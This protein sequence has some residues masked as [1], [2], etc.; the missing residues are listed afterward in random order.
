MKT[1][2][3]WGILGAGIIIAG[4]GYYALKQQKAGDSEVA[5]T[6]NSKTSEESQ[7][8]GKFTGSFQSLL[9]RSGSWKCTIDVSTQ[10]AVSS[11]VTY[12]SNGKVRGDF[13]SGV[14][15][16]GNIESHIIADGT[17]AYTWTSAYPQGFKVKLAATTG[18]SNNGKTPQT[19]GNGFD[20]NQNYSYDCQAWNGDV[21]LFS[22][23]AGIT[24]QEFGK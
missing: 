2:V 22:L 20:V 13:T 12:V 10:K 15:G 11:G 18:Q 3:L 9:R 8:S 6:G 21:S 23:P 4:V 24:F 16:Y 7:Q 5:T 17:Y 1:T 19:S 14:Q